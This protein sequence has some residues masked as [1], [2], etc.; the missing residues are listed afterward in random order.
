MR[1]N[2]RRWQ[3]LDD[4]LQQHGW[5]L[6]V[7][8][9]HGDR[10]AGPSLRRQLAWAVHLK[11]DAQEKIEAAVQKAFEGDGA[12]PGIYD[13]FRRYLRAVDGFQTTFTRLLSS[14]TEFQ[15]LLRQWA[16]VQ[17][18]ARRAGSG[19]RPHATGLGRLQPLQVD[20]H[21]DPTFPGIAPPSPVGCWL[22]AVRRSGLPAAAGA[23]GSGGAKVADAVTDAGRGADAATD[24]G[25]GA[26]AAADAEQGL[27]LFPRSPE[28]AARTAR[29]KSN[30]PKVRG[31][32]N[33]QPVYVHGLQGRA[34]RHRLGQG[35]LPGEGGRDH[36][37]QPGLPGGQGIRLVSCWSGSSGLASRLARRLGTWVMAP[38]HPVG[39]NGDGRLLF[40][41]EE[42]AQGAHW[43]VFD[44]SGV[45]RYR[46]YQ[47]GLRVAIT[48]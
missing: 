38:T 35:D 44:P 24:V 27:D 48:R 31:M 18:I 12:H 1:S 29:Q 39:L 26:D 5:W 10:G 25:R 9:K 3:S 34:V 6:G 2:S 20:Q 41:A 19:L 47:N 23:A 11:E 45:A 37:G 14:T 13:A 21:P 36:R 43:V 40:R 8:P 30:I 28:S 22:R 17:D 16:E 33:V 42:L 32:P 15:G 4:S 46:V 7:S